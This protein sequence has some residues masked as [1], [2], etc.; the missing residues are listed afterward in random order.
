MLAFAEKDNGAIL[1]LTEA[2]RIIGIEVKVSFDTML[3]HKVYLGLRPIE[4]GLVSNFAG[5]NR[6]Y[7]RHLGKRLFT[8]LEYCLYP[9]AVGN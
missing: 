7:P 9:T 5:Y 6:A 4:Y 3:N 1:T 2:L 8:L